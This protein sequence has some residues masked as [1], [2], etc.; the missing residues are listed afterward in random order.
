MSVPRVMGIGNSS[1]RREGGVDAKT[2]RAGTRH[3][4]MGFLILLV[5]LFLISWCSLPSW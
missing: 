4:V 2:R 5:L 1:D 3:L